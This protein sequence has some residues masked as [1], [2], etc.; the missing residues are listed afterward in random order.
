MYFYCP[1]PCHIRHPYPWMRPFHP[2]KGLISRH[3]A[4][5]AYCREQGQSPYPPVNIQKFDISA[6]QF[7]ELVQQARLFTDKIIGSKQ[8]AFDIMNAAQ[9]SDQKKV[10]ELVKSTGISIPF[11][12]KFTPTAIQVILDNSSE[13]VDCCS[14]LVG[15][16]W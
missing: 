3:P 10:E 16:H 11:Q 9:L 13:K 5:V 2:S 6:K 15:L 1:F 8:F 7:Q 4:P 14:L 12:V